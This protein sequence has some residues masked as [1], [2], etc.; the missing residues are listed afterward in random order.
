TT[1]L[2]W[3]SIA[4]LVEET[5]YTERH[6]CRLLKSLERGGELRIEHGGGRGRTKRYRVMGPGEVSKD[7]VTRRKTLTA[8]PKNYDIY[9]VETLTSTTQN[10]D[11][12]C[13]ETLTSRTDERNERENERPSAHAP[14]NKPETRNPFWC[15][16]CGVAI[17]TCAH[18]VIY[19][20]PS[21]Y[22][23]SGPDVDP[24]PRRGPWRNDRRGLREGG[25]RP[26]DD[27]AVTGRVGGP[28]RESCAMVMRIDNNPRTPAPPARARSFCQLVSARFSGDLRRDFP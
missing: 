5:G 10:S 27:R 4:T 12:H 23:G 20:P 11:I 3:P 18:R 13:T 16:A 22:R 2:A 21:R 8:A 9:E 1:G 15:P 28:G 6:V 25:P 7:P 19:A 24:G 14:V 26:P 17:P